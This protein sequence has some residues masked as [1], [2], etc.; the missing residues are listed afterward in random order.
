MPSKLTPKNSTEHLH[1]GTHPYTHKFCNTPGSHQLP[2]SCT[3]PTLHGNKPG[4]S[5]R[6]TPAFHIFQEYF[7]FTRQC[8]EHVKFH[9]ARD[10]LCKYLAF[11]TF[12]CLSAIRQND[13]CRTVPLN[14]ANESVALG[15][16]SKCSKNE[17]FARF[18]LSLPA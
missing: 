5:A 8:A 7:L 11:R 10:Y 9:Q 4:A 18:Q 17:M 15:E 14:F 3:D 13:A 12:V 1:K 2:Y 16:L 6:T